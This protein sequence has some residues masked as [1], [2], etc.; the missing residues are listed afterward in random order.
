M[1]S[2]FIP[3]CFVIS[4]HIKHAVYAFLMLAFCIYHIHVLIHYNVCTLFQLSPS[5]PE[6]QVLQLD[7]QGEKIRAIPEKR[8]ILILREIPQDTPQKVRVGI[9]AS[10]LHSLKWCV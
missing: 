2:I 1:P 7:E 8:C 5:S 9:C 4:V 3:L 6:S 10:Q